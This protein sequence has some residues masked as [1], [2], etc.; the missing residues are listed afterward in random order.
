MARGQE[1]LNKL[2][3]AKGANNNQLWGGSLSSLITWNHWLDN[4]L[5]V[6]VERCWRNW[7]IN[8]HLFNK[9]LALP[10]IVHLIFVDLHLT[11]MLPQVNRHIDERSALP[12]IFHL[13]LVDL[14]LAFLLPRVNWLIDNWLALPEIVCL[15]F[16]DLHLAFFAATSHSTHWQTIGIAW[17]CLSQFCQSP[18]GIFAAT[19]QSTHWRTIGVAMNCLSEFYWCPFSCYLVCLFLWIES[20]DSVEFD[21]QLPGSDLEMH[22]HNLLKE[23]LQSAPR[24]VQKMQL[25][26]ILSLFLLFNKIFKCSQFLFCLCNLAKTW[27]WLTVAMFDSCL[28]GTQPCEWKGNGHQWLGNQVFRWLGLTKEKIRSEISGQDLQKPF[29]GFKTVNSL[30]DDKY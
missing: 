15:S 5:E 14:H 2:V 28:Q 4:Q 23:R 29:G 12:E 11:F 21:F 7:I 16:V 17:N 30:Q 20:N 18:F 22:V 13:S 9:Q 1:E 8:N 19:S 24:A 6:V 10:G 26:P 3:K 25:H 27:V